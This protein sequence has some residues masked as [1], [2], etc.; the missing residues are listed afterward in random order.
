MWQRLKSFT[1]Y[2]VSPLTWWRTL[3]V[4]YWLVASRLLT[5]GRWNQ[6]SQVYNSKFSFIKGKNVCVFYPK[7]KH[8]SVLFL[9]LGQTSVVKTK[10]KKTTK[11]WGTKQLC[12]ILKSCHVD[13][14]IK[15]CR[16]CNL[17]QCYLKL[18]WRS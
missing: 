14:D 18:K 8:L 1:L 13:I 11:I 6:I 10:Q 15:H 7:I 17:H 2:Y 4:L 16:M 5:G 12:L 9:P 3:E